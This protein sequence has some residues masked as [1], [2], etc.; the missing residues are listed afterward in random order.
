[1]ASVH[2]QRGDECAAMAPPNEYLIQLEASA[3]R[4]AWWSAEELDR[5]NAYRNGWTPPD[6]S[7]EFASMLSRRSAGASRRQ[8]STS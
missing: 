8:A 2:V 5:R 1:M 3:I 7:A 4:L 6:M